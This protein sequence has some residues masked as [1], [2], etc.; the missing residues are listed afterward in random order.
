MVR[1]KFRDYYGEKSETNDLAE[2]HNLL[3][4][5][6]AHIQG[7]MV[8]I[9]NLRIVG[10]SGSNPQ[11]LDDHQPALLHGV[12]YRSHEGFSCYRGNYPGMSSRKDGRTAVND[13]FSKIAMILD[14]DTSLESPRSYGIPVYE[15]SVCMQ[16]WVGQFEKWL[17][18]LKKRENKATLKERA[19]PFYYMRLL[20][21]FGMD[22]KKFGLDDIFRKYMPKE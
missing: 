21:D 16:N 19:E 13:E 22:A 10:L 8:V 18:E 15:D 20:T 17:V 4:R 6:I 11:E 3:S 5:A 7:K 9:P 12:I 2:A 1:Y 14:A